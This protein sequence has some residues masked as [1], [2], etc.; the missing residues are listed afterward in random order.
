MD[1]SP[2][3]LQRSPDILGTAVMIGDRHQIA[4]DAGEGIG[5]LFILI[6]YFDNLI[7]GQLFCL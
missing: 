4:A 3:V 7:R 6:K 2:A 1:S 5:V